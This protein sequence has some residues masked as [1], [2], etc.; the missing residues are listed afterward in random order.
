MIFKDPS[1]SNHSTILSSYETIIVFLLRAGK[2]HQ[3]QFLCIFL[4]EGAYW[5]PKWAEADQEFINEVKCQINFIN[6]LN[7][8]PVVWTIQ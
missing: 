6:S 3:K 5:E 8:L 1:N 7:Q 4:G 2:H